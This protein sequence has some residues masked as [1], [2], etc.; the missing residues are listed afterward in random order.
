MYRKHVRVVLAACEFSTT[1]AYRY[2]V[3]WT[4]NGSTPQDPENRTHSFVETRMCMAVVWSWCYQEC[5]MPQ[6]D[7]MSYYMKMPL[8]G[9]TA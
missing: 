9:P 1:Q 8:N 5:P 3:I 2:L 6:N 4:Y 7:R